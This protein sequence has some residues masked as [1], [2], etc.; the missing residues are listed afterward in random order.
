MKLVILKILFQVEY[1]QG[2]LE[3]NKISQIGI[4][5]SKQISNCSIMTLNTL[6]LRQNGRHFPDDIFKCTFLNENV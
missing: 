2:P 3:L 1:F 6:R 5:F 4:E